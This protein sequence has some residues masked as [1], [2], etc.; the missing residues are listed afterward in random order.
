MDIDFKS[1]KNITCIDRF[2]I[3]TYNRVFFL[4]RKFISVKN[5]FVNIFDALFFWVGLK[6]SILIRLSNRSTKRFFSKNEFYDWYIAEGAKTVLLLRHDVHID[7][8]MVKFRWNNKTIKFIYNTAHELNDI[9]RMIKE[10]FFDEEYMAV[11]VNGKDVIDIGANIGD[12]AIYF[13]LKGARHV[14]AFEPDIRLFNAALKNIKINGLKSKVTIL[15]KACGKSTTIMINNRKIESINL[16]SIINNFLEP[17]R[18]AVLKCDCEGCEY[19]VIL[20]ANRKTLR[21]FDQIMIEAHYGYIN[22]K[23]K[24]EYAGFKTKHTAPMPSFL[25]GGGKEAVYFN[26]IWAQK[27]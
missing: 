4:V 23:E 19:S 11:D 16:N 24:L 9:I 10:N 7:K 27:V 25:H 22:L 2:G 21:R 8:G 18:N 12:T 3:H 14:Y 5:I 6:N 15:N 26:L 13:A 1:N 17:N 20:N